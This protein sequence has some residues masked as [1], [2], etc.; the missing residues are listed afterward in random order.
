ML[1]EL[2]LVI[3]CKLLSSHAEST[4]C[5]NMLSKCTFQAVVPSCMWDLIL[6]LIVAC[7]PEMPHSL[8]AQLSFVELSSK[9]TGTSQRVT[10]LSSHHDRMLR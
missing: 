8:Q 3:E 6:S 5:S 2:T 7:I 1:E 9:L 4:K 10:L